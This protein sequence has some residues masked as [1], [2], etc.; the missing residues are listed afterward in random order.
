MTE[1][2]KQHIEILIRIYKLGLFAHCCREFHFYKAST[3]LKH[4][5]DELIRSL[6]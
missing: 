3:A 1:K 2:D 6:L 4:K 5:R